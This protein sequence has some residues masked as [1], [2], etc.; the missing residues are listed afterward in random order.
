MRREKEIPISRRA[1]AR[2]PELHAC[3]GRTPIRT[4]LGT[5]GHPGGL[6]RTINQPETAV[7]RVH[8]R[9]YAI[10]GVSVGLLS[11]CARE[12]GNSGTSFSHHESGRIPLLLTTT[13]VDESFGSRYK[14]RWSCSS[15][16]LW[17]MA[18]ERAKKAG[19]KD[20]DSLPRSGGCL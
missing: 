9:L 13:V 5:H 11:S 7:V 16:S 14:Y 4:T 15:A 20:A 17:L 8:E 18:V 10:S 6:V 2:N 19:L 3:I 12:F 1:A